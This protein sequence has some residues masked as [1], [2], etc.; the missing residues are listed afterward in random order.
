M[1]REKEEL[2]RK[3]ASPQKEVSQQGEAS[4]AMSTSTMSKAEEH[5]RMADVEASFEDR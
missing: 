1:E 3:A 2:L 4:E 5:G